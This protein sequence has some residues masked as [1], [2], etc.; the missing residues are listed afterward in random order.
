[1]PCRAI[2]VWGPAYDGRYPESSVPSVACVVSCQIPTTFHMPHHQ[3]PTE[4]RT[5]V[6]SPRWCKLHER[7]CV[8]SPLLGAGTA[9][10]RGV[11]SQGCVAC[12]HVGGCAN[13]VSRGD[14]FHGWACAG[15]V[16]RA[17]LSCRVRCVTCLLACATGV[18]RRP[19]TAVNAYAT[20]TQNLRTG[21]DCSTCMLH[22]CYVT[23]NGLPDGARR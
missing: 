11:A 20:G 18:C 14:S 5:A 10:C 19:D 3:C 13:F 12:M 16:V 9:T 4:C 8:L 7:L 1:M 17:V 22:Y 23:P 15:A 2:W 6:P 21:P